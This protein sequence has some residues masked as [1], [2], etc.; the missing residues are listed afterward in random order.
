MGNEMSDRK[1]K[2]KP[3]MSRNGPDGESKKAEEGDQTGDYQRSICL[4]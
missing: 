4:R 2:A 1:N 3:D